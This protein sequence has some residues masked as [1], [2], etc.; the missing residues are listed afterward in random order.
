MPLPCVA[1]SVL[2]HVEKLSNWVQPCQA[3]VNGHLCPFDFSLAAARATSGQV[4]GGLSVEI[5]AAANASL[6]K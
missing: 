1:S 4:A 6:L 3:I 5:P 2:C